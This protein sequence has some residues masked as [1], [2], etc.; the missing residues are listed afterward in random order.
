MIRPGRESD[1]LFD[2]MDLFNT[3]LALAGAI[4]RIPTDRYI[5]GIDQTSFLLTDD[6][7]SKREKV[8]VWSEKDLMAMRMYEYKIHIKIVADPRPVAGH[9]H[10][11]QSDIGLAPWLF[12]LYIDPK[13]QY[14]VGHRMNAWL[15]SL[16]AEMKAHAATFKKYPPKDIGLG[17]SPATL[18]GA[19][20]SVAA[21]AH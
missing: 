11:H 15:A 5:D 10:D 19:A 13:E 14:P 16:A 12:N 9:R 21:V 20:W 1:D 17:Q 3:S 2:L 4:D 6:G 8:Y 18:P 7:Q